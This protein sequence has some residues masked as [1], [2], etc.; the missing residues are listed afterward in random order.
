MEV[1]VQL[2][3]RPTVLLTGS[4]TRWKREVDAPCVLSGESHVRDSRR[5]RCVGVSPIQQLP[6]LLYDGDCGFC[7]RSVR[8]VERM[9]VRACLVPWQEADLA[10]LSTT[11]ARARQE[12]L[13][14]TP[15]R[16]VFGGAAAAVELLKHCR[17]A[18]R[19]VGWIMSLRLV[20]PL[21]H[22]IYGGIAAYRYH[23]PGATPACQLP[24]HQRPGRQP[25][26]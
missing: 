25:R 1:S 21:A 3:F 26:K 7:T 17:G 5:E 8:M 20:R 6:V 11:E 14:V 13:W 15:D 2:G 22:W 18:W 24:P 10:D 16:R 9:P 19:T 12:V 23:L 4:R